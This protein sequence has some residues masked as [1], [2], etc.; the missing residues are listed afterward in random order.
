MS[1]G[2]FLW[3]MNAAALRHA[4]GAAVCL[5]L[6]GTLLSLGEIQGY[7]QKQPTVGHPE[8]AMEIP[9]RNL[10]QSVQSCNR[11]ILTGGIC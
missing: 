2:A 11:A 1:V 10:S 7:W 5:G 8:V 4:R 3:C 9:E 6:H